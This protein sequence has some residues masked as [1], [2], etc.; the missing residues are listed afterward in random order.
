[1][2]IDYMPQETT[3]YWQKS[4]ASPLTLSGT[5]PSV[6]DVVVIGGGVLGAST[7]YWLAHAGVAPV[8]LERAGLAY[9]ATGRNGGFV[10]TGL[11]EPY[12]VAIEQLGHET[13][14]AIMTLTYENLALLRQ[15]LAEE[16]IACEYRV[17]GGLALA[18]NECSL[19]SQAQEAALL[20]ADDF[21][22]TVLDREQMQALVKTP[23]GT[24]I[25]GGTFTPTHGTIHPIRLVQGLIQATQRYGAR[26]Y[27][28]TALQL[29]SDEQGVL[30]HT[31]HGMIHA[32]TVIVAV[33]AWTG[34]LIPSLEKFIVPVRGQA[35][36]YAPIEQVF[37]T[38]INAAITAT[39]EYW[40][41]RADG[42][43]IL[44]GCRAAAPG[45][46]R[47]IL[48]HCTT[49]EVQLA[50]EQIFPRL[51]PSLSEKLRV[52]HRWA[53][54]MAFTTDHVPIFDRVPDMPG[55]IAAGGFCGHG[56]P[57]VIRAGQLL[58]EAYTKDTWPP[59]LVP[60]RLDRETLGKI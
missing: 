4:V 14:R 45:L 9:G 43:I 53:G 33:N 7:A 13:A 60:F 17:S 48:L 40:Q 44:G 39:G 50:L 6:A 34:R 11:A 12:S 59:A 28:T 47:G 26:I 56:M 19:A 16:E 23:L 57:F 31:E 20:Q 37:T 38:G 41:Q 1:M 15:I 29:A 27:R 3:S 51:F 24:E 58:A 52:A 42:T 32:N 25:V 55:V 46:D 49:P 22:K 18:L 2:Y 10:T 35:L 21:L 36:A 5:F 54:L 8:L 30:I